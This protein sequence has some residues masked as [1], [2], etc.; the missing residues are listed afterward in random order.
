M[1]SLRA[2]TVSLSCCHQDSAWHIVG[3]P[4]SRTT[5]IKLFIGSQSLQSGGSLS[6]GGP[7]EAARTHRSGRKGTSW[8]GHYSSPSAGD[9]SI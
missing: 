9:A 8:A 1:S 2:E 5:L 7:S 4:T 3:I 6:S